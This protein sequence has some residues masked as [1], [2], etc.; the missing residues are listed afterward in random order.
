[1]S[2]F[3][4]NT[5][6]WTAFVPARHKRYA[7]VIVAVVKRHG[8]N[9]RAI[10]EDLKDAGVIAVSTYWQDVK[11]FQALQAAYLKRPEHECSNTV[12]F[13]RHGRPESKAGGQIADRQ[14]D[15]LVS[16]HDGDITELEAAKIII[17]DLS[18]H[19]GDITE[20]NETFRQ[21]RTQ[22]QNTISALKKEIEVLKGE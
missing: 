17:D 7:E 10:V 22:A 20:K 13:D 6:I 18:E 2:E 4:R 5:H 11:C 14:I 21:G 19:D 3:E 8:S 15:C 9:S 12:P 16:A 1:M